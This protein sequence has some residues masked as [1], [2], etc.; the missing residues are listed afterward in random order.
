MIYTIVN[1][2]IRITEKEHMSV[3]V[4]ARITA[5]LDHSIRKLAKRLGITYSD[6]IKDCL[7]NGVP[8]WETHIEKYS[9]NKKASF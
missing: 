1:D 3:L 4:S 5:E 9:K 6:V 8:L 2:Y 7:K